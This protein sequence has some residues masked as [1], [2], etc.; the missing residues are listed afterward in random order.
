MIYNNLKFHLFLLIFLSISSS[1]ICQYEVECGKVKLTVPE[2][3]KVSTD[4]LKPFLVNAGILKPIEQSEA[5]LELRFYFDNV[6]QLRT[7]VIKCIRDS[8]FADQYTTY[9]SSK[10]SNAFPIRGTKYKSLGYVDSLKM[11]AIYKKE[12]ICPPSDFKWQFFLDSLVIK[13]HL[14]DLPGQVE[15]D[16]MSSL[17]AI[18]KDRKFSYSY[19]GYELWVNGHSR[20]F[21][22]YKIPSYEDNGKTPTITYYKNISALLNKLISYHEK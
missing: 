19:V 3:K 17:K 13:N 16:K 11:S 7:V 21:E 20:S 5:K 1:G 2:F 15:M 8:V 14:F 4:A 10:K 9:F 6:S 12:K 22:Q 18:S